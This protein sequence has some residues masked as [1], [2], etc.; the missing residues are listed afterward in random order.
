M[1]DAEVSTAC[2]S[3]RAAGRISARDRSFWLL[4]GK[5]EDKRE[6]KRMQRRRDIYVLSLWT[7][8]FGFINHLQILAF[9]P[10]NLL[11]SQEGPKVWIKKV[12]RK[13]LG[14]S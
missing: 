8:S 4:Y 6:R 12:Q 14:L 9:G 5:Y 3:Q 1:S 11:I 7:L 10:G 2:G 13:E